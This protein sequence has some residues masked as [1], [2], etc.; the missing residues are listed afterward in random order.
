MYTQSDIQCRPVLLTDVP[1]LR[2]NCLPGAS[3]A[4]VTNRVKQAQRVALSG[5]GVGVVALQNGQIV[6]FGQLTL[7]PSAAEIS[8]LLVGTRWRSQG[9]GSTIIAYL[10]R[11]AQ[12]M[13]AEKLEIG[14]AQSNIRALALYRRLGF[15][16][17]RT[18]IL[19]LG[20][21]PEPVIY[22]RKSLDAS[23]P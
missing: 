18:L 4:L 16:D 20:N 15:T 6:G 13:H 23:K 7:Y 17:Y 14:A 2:I 12:D 21:G 22:L 1:A 3:L 5:R 11:A 10:T 9:V 8:N 19:D